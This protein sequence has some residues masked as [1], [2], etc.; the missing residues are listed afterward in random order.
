MFDQGRQNL[1]RVWPDNEL[2][3]I[4]A[5]VFGYAAGVMQLAE[6]LLVKTDRE[7]F[8]LFRR[9]LGH[10]SHDGARIDTAGKKSAE[11]NFRHQA[12]A[13]CFAQ[14]LDHALTGFFLADADLF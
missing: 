4:G 2:V 3:M 8:Y 11:R 1:H 10:Q 12:H 6:V 7:G 14:Q 9:L 13:H 5:H